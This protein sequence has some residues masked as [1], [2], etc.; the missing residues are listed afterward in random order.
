MFDHCVRFT[1]LALFTGVLLG[2]GCSSDGAGAAGAPSTAGSSASGGESGPRDGGGGS[3]GD[4]GSAAEA[5]EAGAP[6]V[7]VEDHA[8]RCASPRSG[9]DPTTKAKFVDV[10]GRV[11]DEQLWLQSWTDDT[12]LWFDEVPETDLKSF[13]TALDYFDVLKTPAVTASGKAKDQFHF[14][15]ETAAWEAMSQLGT[16]VGFGLQLV[17]ERV[18]PPRLLIAA[19]TQPGSPAESAGIVRGSEVLT[20]DGVD[21]ANGTDVDTLNNGISPVNPN[22]QHTFSI[23][24]P[25]ESSAQTVTLTSVNVPITPVQYARVL[26]A[27]ADK[28]GY[29]SFTDH[30]PAAEKGLVDAV[31][32]L[33]DAKITDL[34]LDIRYNGGGNRDIAA[35]LGYM[36][37]GPA[38]TSGK[39]FERDVFNQKHPTTDPVTGKALMPTPFYD[40]ALGLSV[41]AGKPLPHLD[42]PR[43]FVLTGNGT[44]SA[45]EAVMNG[46]AGVGVEVIQIGDTTCGNPYG[47]YPTDNCGTTYFSS[48]FQSMND[49]GFGDYADGFVPGGLNA[50]CIISDDFSHALGDPAE[51]LLA[52][53]LLYRGLNACPPS[54]AKSAVTSR[55]AASAVLKP[56]WRQNRIVSQPR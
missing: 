15:Y 22:E 12:Y 55:S 21:V 17:L 53:A 2:S 40:H 52:A 5:G 3:A 36:I 28:V 34:V 41:A 32:T 44:C 35:E 18:S 10:Q 45:S 7:T 1:S 49:R 14:S 47:A 39:A 26:P 20:V 43:V 50:G 37:A 16:E 33:S 9:I 19:Y 56:R 51:G 13:A 11:L 23:R 46:L 24:K 6:A 31:T 29:L 42:L 27:P 8:G 4:A 54:D 48:Q 30:V 25:G 38:R